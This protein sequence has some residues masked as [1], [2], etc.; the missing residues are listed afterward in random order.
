[1]R[2]ALLVV[3]C[4]WAQLTLGAP[5]T[6]DELLKEPRIRGADLSPD[7]AHVAIAFRSDCISG[8]SGHQMRQVRAAE[9]VGS[10]TP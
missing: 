4:L 1:M 5:H 7:G 10:H 6:I 2:A 8:Q 9:P 3:S